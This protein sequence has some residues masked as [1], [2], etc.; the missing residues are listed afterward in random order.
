MDFKNTEHRLNQMAAR[1]NLMVALVFGLLL[2]NIIMASLAWYTSVHQKIEITPFFGA[3]SYIK[4]ETSVDAHY[5]SLMGENII[6]SRLNVTPET[7]TA[8]HKRLLSFIDA[9]SYAL[10]SAQ[11]EREA[12]LIQDKKISSHF[13]ISDIRSDARHLQTTITGTIKRFVG[14]RELAPK[15]RTYAIDYHY[16]HGRLTLT[17]F[18]HT[19]ERTHA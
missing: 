7:V 17:R 3:P 11:L 9:S 2:T 1:S 15:R 16:G 5:L 18:T 6:Y 12:K 14:M 13:E 8:N 19:E 4:S 10:I